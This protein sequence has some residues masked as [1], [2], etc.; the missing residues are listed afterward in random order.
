MQAK[1]NSGSAIVRPLAVL[2]IAALLLVGL[3]GIAV[4]GTGN[5]GKGNSAQGKCKKKSNGA[6]SKG[7]SKS[8][9]KP[10][11]KTGSKGKCKKRKPSK[12]NPKP[13][14]VPPVPPGTP[15]PP[16][17]PTGSDIAPL[18]I[19]T[20]GIDPTSFDF[21]TVQHGSAGTTHAFTVT[22]TGGAP[23]GAPTVS[24]V[25]L[26]NPL[27]GA[28]SAAA[29]TVSTNT[30][31]APLAPAASCSITVKFAPNSN[32]GDATYESRL[33]V[34]ASPGSTASSALTGKAT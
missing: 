7:A 4:A 34:S 13:P 16:L 26:R 32:A 5:K 25:E 1:A 19:S 23:S 3:T 12:G 24:I 10:G 22:N 29:Y 6:K 9:A 33:D 28:G 8:D 14:P 11:S 17:A 20:L 27:I 2:L 30:C 31:T 15:P 21:G 18:P